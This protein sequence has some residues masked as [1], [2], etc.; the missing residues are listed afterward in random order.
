MHIY[1][2]DYIDY[3]EKLFVRLGINNISDCIVILYMK[4][5]ITILHYYK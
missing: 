1:K 5:I 3:H 4:L 2:F